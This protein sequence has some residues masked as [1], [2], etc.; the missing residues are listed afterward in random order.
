MRYKLISMHPYLAMSAENTEYV[1][2]YFHRDGAGYL[3][4][5][6]DSIDLD[7][8]G[9]TADGAPVISKDEFKFFEKI[10]E[11]EPV[12]E[13]FNRDL[14]ERIYISLIGS[15]FADMSFE[16]MWQQAVEAAK[17]TK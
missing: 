1:S 16:C 5:T 15:R 9:L 4:V 14:A 7:G 13:D 8:H 17:T 2:K 3:T 11:L 6:L 12:P 10:E